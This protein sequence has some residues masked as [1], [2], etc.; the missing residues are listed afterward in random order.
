MEKRIDLNKLVEN[1]INNFTKPILA[2][3]FNVYKEFVNQELINPSREQ[4]D[5]MIALEQ[6]I[7]NIDQHLAQER[8]AHKVGAR[9]TAN[10]FI[11]IF[12]VLI[13][14]LFFMSFLVKNNR[15]LKKYR[16]I[17]SNYLNE[18]NSMI[19][20]KNNHLLSIFANH[21][22]NDIK[23]AIW[24]RFNVNEIKNYK[25]QEIET[26]INLFNK[27]VKGIASI[28]KY[29][30]RNSVFYD[31][32]LVYQYIQNI[33]TSASETRY[34]S[35]GESYVVTSVH[36]EP[37]PFIEYA[38]FNVIPTNYLPGLN[39]EETDALTSRQIAKMKKRGEYV[40]ENEEFCKSYWFRYNKEIE[41][42]NYF[43]TSTQQRFLDYKSYI[44][45]NK[46]K[47]SKISKLLGSLILSNNYLTNDTY[48]PFHILS[49]TN[50][51]PRITFNQIADY[52][53]NQIYSS[54][55]TTILNISKVYLQKNLAIENYE[56]N[57][58]SF[59]ATY[60]DQ[61]KVD[62]TK[63]IHFIILNRIYERMFFDINH[64]NMD[65][66]SWFELNK[67]YPIN[68]NVDLYVIQNKS[69]YFE[70][71]VDY[72]GQVP[73]PYKRYYPISEEK[74]VLHLK[75]LIDPEDIV[76]NTGAIFSKKQ[77]VYTSMADL[78]KSNWIIPKIYEGLEKLNNI[79]EIQQFLTLGNVYAVI[80]DTGVYLFF[81]SRTNY[82]E[83]RKSDLENY[84]VFIQ[85]ATYLYNFIE[86]EINNRF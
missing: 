9:T 58:N 11:I 20:Q 12:S 82:S 23:A 56:T 81:N 34:N 62:T 17:E 76:G 45:E 31:L 60:K 49:L 19:D 15:I 24:K 53:Y 39:F 30:I 64:K 46:L 83:T 74:Y 68:S 40:L 80:D 8:K 21:S 32:V 27:D 28:S 52:M 77:L 47:E 18:Q 51:N 29:D 70:E 48:I 10:V 61:E 4:F 37:T 84:N 71:Q 65:K 75:N 57:A 63:S 66:L 55:V 42:I 5:E 43:S 22:E 26:A 54:L 72:S 7:T 36:D 78:K 14:G 73:V 1:P 85:I 33:R 69:Y 67:I 25:Y 86:S 59:I 2:N 50:N 3:L 38:G 6:K 41:F 44:T 13:I 16:E 35:K 79:R